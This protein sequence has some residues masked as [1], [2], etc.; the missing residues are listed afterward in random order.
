MFIADITNKVSDYKIHL[1]YL[2]CD[3]HFFLY[4]ESI[5]QIH[6]DPEY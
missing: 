2:D 5:L 4:N 1:F 6:N 3:R